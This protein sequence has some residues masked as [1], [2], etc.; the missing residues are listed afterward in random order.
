MAIPGANPF[1]RG[2]AGEGNSLPSQRPSAKQFDPNPVIGSQPVEGPLPQ[3]PFADHMEPGDVIDI[4]PSGAPVI[5]SEEQAAAYKAP[6]VIDYHE[7]KI[8]GLD[9]CGRCGSS[10]IEYSIE[11]AALICQNCRFEDKGVNVAERFGN[12]SD[13]SKLNSRSVTSGAQRILT[14]EVQVTIEC[15]GCGAEVVVDTEK[16]LEA[17]CHWCR[18]KLSINNQIP[19]GAVPDGILPFRITKEQ[20]MENVKDFVKARKAFANARFKKEF[21]PENVFGVYLPYIVA[22]AKFVGGVEGAAEKHI[23]SYS[24]GGKNKTTYYDYD[25]YE[26]K[27]E[28]AVLADD[29]ALEASSKRQIETAS[30]TN[31]VINAVL[32]FPIEE[33]VDFRAHYL[34]NFNAERRDM[35]T[36]DLDQNLV[37][38]MLTVIRAKADESAKTYE[39]RGVRWERE[40]T[41]LLGAHQ[42]SIYL[43]VWLYSF[44]EENAKNPRTGQ[45]G[46]LIH[47]IAVNGVTGETM[48]SIPIAWGKL[49]LVSW[50]IG[51]TVGAPSTY[52]F[53]WLNGFFW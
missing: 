11:K 4:D 34:S 25:E 23:R 50:I 38:A 5:A 12:A 28:L 18:Q 37:H 3:L 40:W 39:K 51:L 8:I 48:G 26:V 52:A 41:Q 19:N 22:D 24:S 47:Y 44:V 36:E 46:Q 32:P 53:L 43:P 9:K 14:D 2:S 6:E 42:A 16:T 10:A 31:N 7:N 1:A 29:I 21:Q 17:R 49:H 45:R 27:R 35:D 30:N 15:Q 20:A 13:I 33:A